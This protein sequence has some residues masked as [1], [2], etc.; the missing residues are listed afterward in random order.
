M[1]RNF[2]MYR[3]LMAV[4]VVTCL[5]A[6]QPSTARAACAAANL[7]GKWDVYSTGFGWS[8]CTIEVLA[9]GNDREG[10]SCIDNLNS[11]AR[12]DGGRLTVYSNCHVRGYVIK[13]E[14][15]FSYRTTI[16]RATMNRGKALI[17][18]VTKTRDIGFPFSSQ[19]ELFNAV[20]R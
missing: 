9:C 20:K 11:Q 12:I 8:K 10:S 19:G 3:V 7:V 6:V 2:T 5:S 17:V 4:L 14:D 15:G 16:S 13:R 1:G 18:G